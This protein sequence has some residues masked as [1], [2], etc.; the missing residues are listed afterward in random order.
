MIL[1]LDPAQ[2]FT[3]A[4]Q[5]A[6]QSSG[7][8]WL[9][10]PDANVPGG[11]EL[12]PGQSTTGQTLTINDP[13][14]LTINYSAAVSGTPAGASAPVFDTKPVTGVKAGAVYTYQAI[15]HDPDGSTPGYLLAGGPAG[16][17]VDPRTGAR[18][19]EDQRDQPRQRP[20]DAGRVRPQR[21]LHPPD[22]SDRGCRRQSRAADF[23]IA[24]A[25]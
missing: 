4:P 20:R 12:K 6:T 2:G 9:V 10:Q 14:H 18:H 13:N 23:G 7:G 22:I 25:D 17:T 11:V 21:Q 15:A 3:G 8:L 5:N 19:L 1:L 24:V 16:M